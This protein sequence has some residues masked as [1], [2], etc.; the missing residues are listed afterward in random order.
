LGGITVV[1]PPFKEKSLLL[2]LS[3]L[4]VK[5]NVYFLGTRKVKKKG[6]VLLIILHSSFFFEH[7]SSL[8]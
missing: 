4:S 6:A 7:S 5:L 8:L 2:L 3:S 1:L